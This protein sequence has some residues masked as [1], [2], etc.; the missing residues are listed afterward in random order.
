MSGVPYGTINLA[1]I[2]REFTSRRGEQPFWYQA[3]LI[4][5]YMYYYGGAYDYGTQSGGTRWE[6][7]GMHGKFRHWFT[8]YGVETP[9]RGNYATTGELS[10]FTTVHNGYMDDGYVAVNLPFYINIQG[11]NYSTAYVGSN[12]Y[13]TFGGGA[14]VYSSLSWSNPSLPKIMCGAQ[15]RN[16]TYCGVAYMTGY[17]GTAGNIAVTIRYEGNSYYGSNTS[18]GQADSV[19]EITFINPE[20]CV[21]RNF[22]GFAVNTGAYTGSNLW[23]IGNSS[24]A[25]ISWNNTA[26]YSYSPYCYEGSYPTLYGNWQYYSSQPYNYWHPYPLGSGG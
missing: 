4:E 16:M 7:N 15:D 25:L 23:G 18:R 6:M 1:G 17:N 8:W 26:F 9:R 13:I 14:S 10:G 22:Q 12:G 5:Q 21:N 19:Y 2:T 20:N 3:Y 11:G 24:S